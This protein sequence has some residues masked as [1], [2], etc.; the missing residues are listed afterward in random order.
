MHVC[1]FVC[2][3]HSGICVHVRDVQDFWRV[4]ECHLCK[5]LCACTEGCVW[6]ASWATVRRT[7]FL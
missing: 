1:V 6:G 5:D 3:V 7:L 4:Y 2:I